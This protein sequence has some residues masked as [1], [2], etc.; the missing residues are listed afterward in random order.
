MLALPVL[1]G[2]PG[3]ASSHN[4]PGTPRLGAE[5]PA[6][7]NSQEEVKASNSPMIAADPTEP[8]FVVMAN[9]LD[10]ADFG[11]ALQISGN[12]GRSFVPANPVPR[13]PKGAQK[14]YAPEVAFDSDGKL[15]YLFVGLA[16]RTNTPMGVFLTSSRD[17]GRSFTPPRKVLGPYSF[18]VRM[19][20]DRNENRMHIVW[21]R[22][23]AQPGL[24]SFPPPPNPILSIFSDDG[25]ETFSKPLRVSDP[26]RRYVVAPALALGPKGRVHVLYYDLEED[27]RDY[28]GLEGP[29]WEGK[30]SVVLAGSADGGRTFS[31]G[32]IVDDGVVPPERVMLI[33]TMAPPALVAGPS[34]RLFA[35]WHDARSGDWDVW[36]RSSSD[37]GR[38]WGDAV[39]VNDDPPSNGLHQYLPRLS[40]AGGRLDVIFY[41]RRHD[42]GNLRNDVFYAAS[43]DGGRS[44]SPNLKLTDKASDSKIGQRYAGPAAR[45]QVEFGSRLGLF[46]TPTNVVASW[47]DTRNSA[48]PLMQDVFSRII[49]YSRRGS[50]PAGAP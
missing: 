33:F 11:C 21:I 14:C 13:L 37:G 28:H 35:A 9:R 31:Q 26:G 18:G 30:W 49:D 2:G 12:A 10:A 42:P 38:T 22:A 44:F 45:D 48:H 15:H 41:D 23:N 46:S 43:R 34:G 50:A 20:I 1:S 16:G 4:S 27:A 29:V 24:G 32:R 7:S 47:T 3:N 40:F 36:L 19:A 17:R 8:R 6:T 39:R 25:G 5:L